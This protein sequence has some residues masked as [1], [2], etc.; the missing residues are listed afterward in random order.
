MSI[1]PALI[2]IC[3]M[4]TRAVLYSWEG[5]WREPRVENCPKSAQQS[6][7]ESCHLVLAAGAW[8]SS[9]LMGRGCCVTG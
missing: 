9:H 2:V 3:P 4:A 7:G 8:S 5:S 6:A 1:V